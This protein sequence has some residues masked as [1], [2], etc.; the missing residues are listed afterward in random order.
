MTF[1]KVLRY[2]HKDLSLAKSWILLW[3]LSL[4]FLNT[5]IVYLYYYNRMRCFVYLNLAK[6]SA[7]SIQLKISFNVVVSLKFF[8]LS[9]LR[10]FLERRFSLKWWYPSE[11]HIHMFCIDKSTI[12]CGTIRHLTH[13]LHLVSVFSKKAY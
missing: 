5:L 8:S 10:F 9:T 2:F 13:P 7:E 1:F 6:N 3:M 11:W 4:A 12:G